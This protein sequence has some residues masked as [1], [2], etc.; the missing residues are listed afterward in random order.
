MILQ[1]LCFQPLHGFL[2]VENA[3]FEQ[4]NG[5]IDIIIC[6]R[7][8]QQIRRGHRR[9]APAV[10]N[11]KVQPR[12]IGGH[13]PPDVQKR[14][15]F[16]KI[17]FIGRD[18]ADVG[19]LSAHFYSCPALGLLIRGRCIK[20]GAEVQKRKA[21]AKSGEEPAGEAAEEEKKPAAK[22]AAAKKSASKKTTAKKTTA[23]KTAAKAKDKE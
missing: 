7:T 1:N 13:K 3:G 20:T 9:G 15:R 11:N 21:A 8:D 22:K 18:C 12:P 2:R 5:L 4:A 6:H 23:K 16:F 10:L 19:V 14:L 17:K